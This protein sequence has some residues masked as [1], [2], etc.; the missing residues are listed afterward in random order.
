MHFDLFG[1]GWIGV[2]LFFVISGFVIALSLLRTI[3]NF[4]IDNYKKTYF[5]NRLAR[6]VPLYFL[7]SWCYLVLVAPQLLQE[8]SRHLWINIFS[9]IFFVHN[10]STN[11]AEALNSPAWTIAIEMQF[12]IFMAIVF[13]WLPRH[14][15]VLVC[16]SFIVIALAWRAGAWFTFDPDLGVAHRLTRVEQLPGRLDAFGLG[17]AIALIVWDRQH[18]LHKHLLPNWKNSISWLIIA[19]LLSLLWWEILWPHSDYWSF[20]GMVIF[21]RLLLVTSFAAW[22][23]FLISLRNNPVLIKILSPVSYVGK[24]SYGVY[25]WHMLVIESIAKIDSIHPAW[26]SGLVVVLVLLIASFTWHF[27]EQPLIRRYHD[28]PSPQ[29]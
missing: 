29:A 12:Y 6:I 15:P 1:I 18:P 25:L 20:S 14:R 27:F 24:I 3:E 23:C 26:A 22:I 10:L 13:K 4:G 17:C 16:A 9:H 5:I 21:F 7:T 2:D 11:Y 28:Q 8:P 19:I